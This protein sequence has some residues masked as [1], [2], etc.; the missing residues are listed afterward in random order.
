MP[1]KDTVTCGACGKQVPKSAALTPEGVNYTMHFCSLDCLD[2]WKH[3]RRT[4]EPG[5][6]KPG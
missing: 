6:R 4:Q 2:R 3:E 1:E 5:R